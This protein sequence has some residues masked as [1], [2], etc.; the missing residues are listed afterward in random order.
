MRYANH[1]PFSSALSS[2]KGADDSPASTSHTPRACVSTIALAILFMV[3]AIVADSVGAPDQ[4]AGPA[5]KIA[6]AAR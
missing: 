4:E 6:T 2:T 1:S 5:K 3:L